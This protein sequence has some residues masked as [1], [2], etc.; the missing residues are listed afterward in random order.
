MDTIDTSTIKLPPVR[1]FG[2]TPDTGA[3]G[4]KMQPLQTTNP[5]AQGMSNS[6]FV[7]AQTATPTTT[8]AQTA[9]NE[10]VGELAQEPMPEDYNSP[11]NIRRRDRQA[12]FAAIGDGISAL[13]NLYYASKGAPS[14]YDG[15]KG[16]AAQQIA[17]NQA[18]RGR[19]DKLMQQ[20]RTNN[21]ERIKAY[22]QAQYRQ[23]QIKQMELN[24]KYRL[25]SLAQRIKES[26][27]KQERAMLTAEYNQTKAEID[28][29][30]LQFDMEKFATNDD[31][32]NRNLRHQQD[33]LN[34]QKRDIVTTKEGV[35]KFGRPTKTITTT[36]RR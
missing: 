18:E 14:Q 5:V 29:L 24:Y 4:N 20:W 30:K 9:Y 22:N 34:W 31:Y 32:R 10:F 2:E 27:D 16:M 8:P 12:M 6:E 1:K 26:N 7:K 35:D 23:A 3:D 25:D 28:M 15:S 21:I 19:Y 11:D 13:S 33:R 36:S 17:L